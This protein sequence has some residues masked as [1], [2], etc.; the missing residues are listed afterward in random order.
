MNDQYVLLNDCLQRRILVLDIND[1]FNIKSKVLCPKMYFDRFMKKE[2]HPLYR[3]SISTKKNEY[4]Q[5]KIG[6]NL[7][8]VFYDEEILLFLTKEYELSNKCDKKKSLISKA[9]TFKKRIC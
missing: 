6:P 1:K 3:E 9:F 8:K 4:F 5:F 7:T 2:D